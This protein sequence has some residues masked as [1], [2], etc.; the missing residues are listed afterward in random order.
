MKF[1]S[2]NR[3]TLFGFALAGIIFSGVI[4][5]SAQGPV[6]NESRV[7][8]VNLAANTQES[9]ELIIR[10]YLLKNPSIIREAMQALQAQEA[11]ENQRRVAESLRTLKS[12]LYSDTESPSIGNA[13]ADV[14]IVV[15]FDYNCGHCKNSL[16]ALQ[17]LV[18]SDPSIRI[19][20]KELPIMGPQSQTAAFAAL[21]AKRQG[22]YAEF[23]VAL[24]ESVEI[25]EEVIKSISDRLGLNYATLQKDMSDP[26]LNEALNRNLRLASTLGIN[27]TPGYVVG[28]QIIPGAIDAGTLMN[29][30]N[31][32]RGK[33]KEVKSAG[34]DVGAMK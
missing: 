28:G 22:K 19:V 13:K 23:H 31:V 26:R 25:N 4:G 33:L 29:F 16:P 30:L 18:A 1:D 10:N 8:N 11:A 17:N 7:E 15:F 20:Y 6:A 3:L 5:V 9:I 12:D 24:M 2:I 34:K 14:P 27:G 21:A 32:E